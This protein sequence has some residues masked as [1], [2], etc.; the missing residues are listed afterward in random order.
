MQLNMSLG[1]VLE[2]SCTFCLHY[3]YFNCT[4]YFLFAVCLVGLYKKNAEN[5]YYGDV[6]FKL[7][8]AKA[9][10]EESRLFYWKRCNYYGHKIKIVH[11]A[12]Y[13]WSWV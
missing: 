10:F 6:S 12:Y 9:D 13:I 7:L 3:G 2:Y 11:V 5:V 1:H 8:C 4:Q